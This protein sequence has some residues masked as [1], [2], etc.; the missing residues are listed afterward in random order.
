MNERVATRAV[1]CG[2]LLAA[3]S[4]GIDFSGGL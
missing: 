4:S 3:C 2:K 1:M